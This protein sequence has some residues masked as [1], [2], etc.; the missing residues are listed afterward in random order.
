MTK[1]HSLSAAVRTLLTAAASRDDRVALPPERLPAAAQ[2]AVVQS[3]L[4]A[5]LIEEIAADDDLPAWRTAED[6]LRFALRVTDAGL[7]AINGG[8]SDAAPAEL[9]ETTRNEP[10][11]VEM[12]AEA[13]QPTVPSEA[14]PAGP[15]TTRQ[16]G[17]R[18]ALQKVA[19]AVLSAW[20]GAAEARPDL[21]A[22][23]DALRFA[24]TETPPA[25][26]ARG[27][28]RPPRTDTKRAAVLAL[29]RRTEG[30]TV[31]QVAEATGWA[32]HTVRGFLAGLKKAGTPVE[33]LERVRQV[34]PGKEGAKGSYTVYRVAE[35][36]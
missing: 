13:P 11:S 18:H 9:S 21:P 8:P 36:S 27:L 31:A 15:A 4:K 35:A 17:P 24:L 22:A 20:D 5:G 14:I 28:S 10:D 32:T 2:R 33:V 29:L 3:L 34:G 25:R 16:A 7:N 12:A 19:S 26:T 6:G 1:A 30:A 23:M